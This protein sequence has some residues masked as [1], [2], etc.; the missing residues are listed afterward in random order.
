MRQ[1]GAFWGTFLGLGAWS[2]GEIFETRNVGIRNCRINGQW[3]TKLCFLDHDCTVVPWSDCGKYDPQAALWG[4]LTDAFYIES[5]DEFKGEMG[6]LRRIYQP[7]TV[8]ITRGERALRDALCAGFRR[9]RWKMAHSKALRSLIDPEYLRT[10]ADWDKMVMSWMQGAL[11][12]KAFGQWAALERA[13]LNSRGYDAE[14][15]ERLIETLRNNLPFLT[16]FGFLYGD[17]YRDFNGSSD[18]FRE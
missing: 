6:C 8:V 10:K 9:T 15:S 12:G 5:E 18:R 13:K 7:G 14:H 17:A 3:R 4:Q 1:L 2:S 11:R 16:R